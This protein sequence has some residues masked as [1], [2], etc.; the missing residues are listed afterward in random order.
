ME[1]PREW[2]QR[3]VEYFESKIRANPL[4]ADYSPENVHIRALGETYNNWIL[5]LRRWDGSL[6]GGSDD[7]MGAETNELIMS[8][9]IDKEELFNVL[10][11]IDAY[12]SI[13]NPYF[14]DLDRLTRDLLFAMVERKG[15][16]PIELIS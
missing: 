2:Y 10:D 5:N 13:S 7:K 14:A 11:K 4:F 3:T 15:Y 16:M 1:N 12:R 8:L 9:G 6:G